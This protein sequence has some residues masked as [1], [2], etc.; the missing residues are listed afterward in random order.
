MVDGVSAVRK[1]HDFR[2]KLKA[3]EVS[4]V[5]RAARTERQPYCLQNGHF[6]RSIHCLG[7]YALIC[8]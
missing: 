6:R 1:A 2:I 7:K 8:S 5:T 4:A 3:D